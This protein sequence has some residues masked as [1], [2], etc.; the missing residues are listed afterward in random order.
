MN[1]YDWVFLAFRVLV[2]AWQ[3]KEVQ[4][5]VAA[6]MATDISGE[7]KRNHVIDQVF[8]A[9]V[10]AKRFIVKALIELALAKLTEES[11][12]SNT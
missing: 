3:I 9:V 8:P 5:L 1:R 6:L 7:A 4:N 10:G 2:K 11:N 12:E